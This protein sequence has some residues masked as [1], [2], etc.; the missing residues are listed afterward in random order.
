MKKTNVDEFAQ[1]LPLPTTGRETFAVSSISL[2]PDQ[3][4]RL[5]TITPGQLY[6]IG[7]KFQLPDGTYSTDE[8]NAILLECF[9]IVIWGMLSHGGTFGKSL[10]TG[11]VVSMGVGMRELFRW[12]IHCNYLRNR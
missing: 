3:V 5:D 4:W 7:W 12:M 9:K 11:S 8:C 6:F 1:N 2:W 10:K